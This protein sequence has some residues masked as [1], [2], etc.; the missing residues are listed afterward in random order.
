MIDD[1]LDG[2]RKHLKED[3]DLLAD[4]ICDSR[5]EKYFAELIEIYHNMKQT[6]DNLSKAIKKIRRG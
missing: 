1:F 5:G 4:I 2:M 6:Y 3:M